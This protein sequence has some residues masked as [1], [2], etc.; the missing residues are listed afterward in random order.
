MGTFF[1]YLFHYRL[2]YH[3][4]HELQQLQYW[5]VF[6]IFGKTSYMAW[7]NV[8]LF[9]AVY[10]Y[11][12]FNIYYWLCCMQINKSSIPI[13]TTHGGFSPLKF[14]LVGKKRITL[15]ISWPHTHILCNCLCF[16]YVGG[17][18]H[19]YETPWFQI[20]W[21]SEKVNLTVVLF[22]FL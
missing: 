20:L 6:S 16:L 12:I 21:E 15:P 9:S 13:G 17:S 14:L 4:V 2:K 8:A 22:L 7:F 11:Y 18:G 3:V 5:S 10:M 19:F 1:H